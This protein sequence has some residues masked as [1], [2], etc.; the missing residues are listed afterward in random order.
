MTQTSFIKQYCR[1][2]KLT[3]EQLNLLGLFSM[4]CN[5]GEEDCEGWAMVDKKW[6]VLSHTKLY[7][8]VEDK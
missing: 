5:C 3:E 8:E 6:A 4:P 7:M 2:S 1:N